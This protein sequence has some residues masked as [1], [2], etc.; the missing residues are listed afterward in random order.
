MWT[1]HKNTRKLLQLLPKIP[2]QN[3]KM[4][5]FSS[6]LMMSIQK[7]TRKLLQLLPKIPHQ[8]RKM[9]FFSSVLMMS[10]HFKNYRQNVI[11]MTL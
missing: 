11:N 9:A 7:N 2:H 10:I 3:R 6:V 5:F 1:S 8:N 4:A